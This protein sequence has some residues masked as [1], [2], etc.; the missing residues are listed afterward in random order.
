[1]ADKSAPLGPD[2]RERVRAYVTNAGQLR[3]T[4]TSISGK[5]RAH[6]LGSV[7]DALDELVAEGELEKEERPDREPVYSKGLAAWFEAARAV[8]QPPPPR[9]PSQRPPRGPMPPGRGRPPYRGGR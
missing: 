1:M 9:D 2:T 7:T 8:D 5:V 4:A 3:Q 6:N